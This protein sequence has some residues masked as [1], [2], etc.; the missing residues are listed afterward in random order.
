[1]A[2]L[3]A[4]EHAAAA[5]SAIKE[6]GYCFSFFELCENFMP[7]F[8]CDVAKVLLKERRMPVIPQLATSTWAD[9]ANIALAEV[10]PAAIHPFLQTR[11]AHLKKGKALA[12]KINKVG[13][14]P[15]QDASCL[16]Y[17]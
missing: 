17:S 5:T 3:M 11:F 15:A 12:D 9:A 4:S 10:V 13:F 1:M 2:S 7:A 16:P 6:H 8:A 14:S